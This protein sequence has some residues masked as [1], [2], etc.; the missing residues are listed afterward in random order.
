MGAVV[1]GNRLGML[2]SRGRRQS[3]V[4]LAATLFGTATTGA[5]AFVM[6]GWVVLG[7]ISRGSGASICCFWGIVSNVSGIG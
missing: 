5:T 2:F 4:D 1:V 3:E 6:V 7:G